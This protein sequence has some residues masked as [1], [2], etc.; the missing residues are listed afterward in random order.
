MT[1]RMRNLRTANHSQH[2]VPQGTLSFGP[3]A[4]CA[5][6]ALKGLTSRVVILRLAYLALQPVF[7]ACVAFAPRARLRLSFSRTLRTQQL[8]IF[9]LG[10][11]LR[12]PTLLRS[13]LVTVQM[14][15]KK[16]LTHWHTQTKGEQIRL[17]CT[18]CVGQHEADAALLET[19]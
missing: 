11:K 8:Y 16:A 6:H 1:S 13:R 17:K 7:S 12:Y 3:M 5:V 2:F 10:P 9:Q 18:A 14:L 4:P 15:E 19:G